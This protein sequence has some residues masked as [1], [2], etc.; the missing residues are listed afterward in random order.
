M[1]HAKNKEVSRGLIANCG[2]LTAAAALLVFWLTP[3]DELV[4]FNLADDAMY[5][6]N[7]FDLGLG[8][9]RTSEWAPL[10]SLF[11]RVEA[12]FIAD[13]LE[14]F[15][16]N[17]ALIQALYIGLIGA[18]VYQA[19]RSVSLALVVCLCFVWGGQLQIVPAV[20][21]FSASVCL[22]GA[23]LAARASTAMGAALVWSWAI[24]LLTFVR[25]EFFVSLFFVLALVLV[26]ALRHRRL[27]I[28]AALGGKQGAIALLLLALCFLA[29]RFPLPDGG[30]SW[31]AFGQHY[32]FNVHEAT[33]Q[34]S[35]WLLEWDPITRA[36]FGD[37]SGPLSALANNPQQFFWHVGQNLLRLFGAVTETAKSVFGHWQLAF[38]IVL[39]A[40][41]L[42]L[43]ATSRK[44]S[45][46]G[47]DGWVR[48]VLPVPLLIPPAVSIVLVFPRDHYLMLLYAL[49]A[50]ILAIWLGAWLNLSKRHDM[51]LFCVGVIV[52]VSLGSPIKPASQA[53]M[54]EIK[55]LRSYE[56]DKPIG[57]LLDA[58]WTRCT[59]LSTCSRLYPVAQKEQVRLADVDSIILSPELEGAAYRQPG[60]VD[61]LQAPQEYGFSSVPLHEGRQLLRRDIANTHQSRQ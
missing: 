40:T 25:L 53:M 44:L 1:V 61:I 49:M 35:S 50:T 8:R 47:F 58:S 27:G 17:G 52:T 4:R 51:A 26:L 43:G 34:H 6:R 10:Y 45:R 33:G 23:L 32:A 3:V 22:A 2:L 19:C 36:D 56:T 11:I 46:E 55:L 39:V 7:A 20:N 37:A 59:F 15:V 42:L 60:L 5:L 28:V 57:A 29:I 9:F 24:Y 18:V 16:V 21:Y 30:R 12:V 48:L 41:F 14:L 38:Y 54:D 31:M 13:P